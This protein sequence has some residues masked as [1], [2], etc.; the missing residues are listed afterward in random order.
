MNKSQSSIVYE[1]MKLETWLYILVG[2][3]SH[4]H[5]LI[6]LNYEKSF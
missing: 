4:E 5:T 3:E 1:H 6:A 2:I